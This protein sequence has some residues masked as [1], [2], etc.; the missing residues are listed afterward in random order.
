LRASSWL[1]P[2]L[3]DILLVIAR[4][5]AWS[6]HEPVRE[7]VIALGPIYTDRQMLGEPQG[8]QATILDQLS[9]STWCR[10]VDGG[11]HRFTDLH[12]VNSINS[13]TGSIQYGPAELSAP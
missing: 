4:R 5:S 7:S 13:L 10:G 2:G 3:A 8:L 1:R 9:E 12:A 6:D 11:E